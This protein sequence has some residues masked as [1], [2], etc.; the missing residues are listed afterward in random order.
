MTN[1]TT[2]GNHFISFICLQSSFIP[3]QSHIPLCLCTPAYP[4]VPRAHGRLISFRPPFG[5]P[6]PQSPSDNE[7]VSIVS[8]LCHAVAAA[9]PTHPLG[10]NTNRELQTHQLDLGWWDYGVVGLRGGESQP[11]TPY[12][13]PPESTERTV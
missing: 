12:T 1:K 5:T 3:S 9:K 6:C 11:T 7:V 2:L 8:S 13:S 4:S 10:V